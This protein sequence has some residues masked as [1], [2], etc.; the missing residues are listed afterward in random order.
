MAGIFDH[1]VSHAE[2]CNVHCI[3]REFNWSTEFSKLSPEEQRRQ[4][5]L[6][7]TLEALVFESSADPAMF[8]ARTKRVDHAAQQREERKESRMLRPGNESA[9]AAAKALRRARVAQRLAERQ[10]IQTNLD[11]CDREDFGR[12]CRKR[13]TRRRTN[14]L[15]GTTTCGRS[16]KRVITGRNIRSDCD[17]NACIRGLYVR[18]SSFTSSC[19]P[20][21]RIGSCGTCSKPASHRCGGCRGIFY[22]GPTCQKAGWNHHKSACC[23]QRLD[24]K[25]Y[26][27]GR[28]DQSSAVCMQYA[29]N[30]IGLLA[31]TYA[32]AGS[33]VSVVASSSFLPLLSVFVSTVSCLLRLL[34]WGVFVLFG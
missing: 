5:D 19:K 27:R 33:I 2:V 14:R 21:E 28:A 16:H 3:V 10:P 29:S 6:E 4:L 8:I 25:S 17:R 22:C 30:P 11:Q 13:A 24:V 26:L 15:A 20:Q 34:E 31:S 12:T 7:G 23:P 1:H 32:Q 18:F 9:A